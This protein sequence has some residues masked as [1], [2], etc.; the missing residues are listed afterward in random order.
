MQHARFTH[1]KYATTCVIAVSAL[2]PMSRNVWAELWPKVMKGPLRVLLK[3]SLCTKIETS[4]RFFVTIFADNY[5]MC[6]FNP[7]FAT[8]VRNY[9]FNGTKLKL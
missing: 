7:V 3:I 2:H 8:S 1:V 4:Y 5:M 6:S 9:I